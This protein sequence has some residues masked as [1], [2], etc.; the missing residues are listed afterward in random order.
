SFLRIFQNYRD[1]KF[2]GKKILR[3]KN[4]TSLVYKTKYFKKFSYDLENKKTY[5][6]CV[7]CLIIAYDALLECDGNF[8]KAIYYGILIHGQIVSIGGLLGG[9]FGILYYDSIPKY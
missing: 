1:T 2:D 8:E 4:S 3:T 7:S 5:D 9:L 6:D